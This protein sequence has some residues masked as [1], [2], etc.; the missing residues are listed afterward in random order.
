[1]RQFQ[2]L[3]ERKATMDAEQNTLLGER[4]HIQGQVG[5]FTDER[6]AVDVSLVKP[7][8]LSSLNYLS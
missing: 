3:A 5:S 4:N 1:M 7:T 8:F 6:G 2:E